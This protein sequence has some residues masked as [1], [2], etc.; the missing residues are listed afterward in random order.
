MSVFTAVVRKVLSLLS[1]DTDGKIGCLIFLVVLLVVVVATLL[2]SKSRIA[3]YIPSIYFLTISLAYFI[4]CVVNS[5]YDIR[6]IISLSVM[7]VIIALFHALRFETGLIWLG[8]VCAYTPAVFIVT[9]LVFIPLRSLV[10]SFG[11]VFYITRYQ[12]VNLALPFDG[13]LHLP[14]IV[15][16]VFLAI[17][18]MLPIIYF[19][20]SRV[21]KV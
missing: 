7:L 5:D 14:Q 17:V 11:K 16:G 13:F 18:I 9:G 12:N 8:D 20:F 6:I 10:G 2:L 3:V 4:G 1:R 15:W 19:S 21:R